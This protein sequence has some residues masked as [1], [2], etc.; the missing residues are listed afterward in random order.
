MEEERRH[1]AAVIWKKTLEKDQGF[2][3]EIVRKFCTIMYNI[4]LCSINLQT[5]QQ[6]VHF[7]LVFCG[8]GSVLEDGDEVPGM[9]SWWVW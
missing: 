7:L 4:F 3:K 5:V 8:V 1:E 9:V 2:L 6:N